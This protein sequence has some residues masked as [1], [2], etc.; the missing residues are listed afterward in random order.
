MNLQTVANNKSISLALGGGLL[1]IAWLL[2]NHAFPWSAFHSEIW[3]CLVIC[4]LAL[5][6]SWTGAAN[7]RV[8][9]VEC[10]VLL[11]ALIPLIQYLKG[12]LA[13]FGQSWIGAGYL[14]LFLTAVVTGRR[15]QEE[16]PG[17]A[18]SFV[19]VAFGI[20]AIVSVGL[21]LY[22]WLRFT[23]SD[24]IL[25]I[26]V[27]AQD[28]SRPYANLGQPNQLATL[29]LLGCLSFG[30]AQSRKLIGATTFIFLLLFTGMGIVLTQS[31][32]ALLTI[33]ICGVALLLKRKIF[34]RSL[35]VHGLW[36]LP[37]FLVSFF[38]IRTI[39][40]QLYLDV[41]VDLL[42]RNT[43]ELRIEIWSMMSHALKDHFYFGFG[44]NNAIEAHV[45]VAEAYPSLSHMIAAQSHNLFL[46]LIVWT[47]LPL[48]M[49]LG[50][51]IVLWIIYV[52]IRV[53]TVFD[54]IC[55]SML[56]VVFI[57]SMFE[58]PLYYAY[59]LLPLGLIVGSQIA[60][61]NFRSL[62]K[63]RKEMVLAW[64]A[65]VLMMVSVTVIDYFRIESALQAIRFEKAR[66]RMTVPATVPSVLVLDQLRA[67]LVM[68][69]TDFGERQA[70]DHLDFEKATRA[71]PSL[72]NMINLIRYYALS[73]QPSEACRW[74]IKIQYL[75]D[76]KTRQALPAVWAEFQSSNSLLRRYVWPNRNSTAEQCVNGISEKIAP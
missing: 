23:E 67:G 48:G 44:W 19:S 68:M 9:V 46:D 63:V 4:G 21:Q 13:F 70:G 41:P 69:K 58:F 14:L 57:H 11:C 15:M 22:Q 16:L 76:E 6:V 61:F 8:S 28:G 35:F 45:S 72:S 49:A 12:E 50:F 3:S 52:L 7:Y 56:M 43:R 53:E 74:M 64:T 73:D 29:L 59:F 1:A 10:V 18:L 55:A 33:L 36:L 31:R 40:T 30:W 20:A 39:S 26:W 54:F 17:S 42:T 34:S 5:V 47:G 66:I 25:D 37:L 2:P 65:V 60:G 32:T 24:G 27:L 38:C 51:A 75:T 62:L 71:M